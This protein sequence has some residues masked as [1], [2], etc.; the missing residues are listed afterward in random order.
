MTNPDDLIKRSDALQAIAQLMLEKVPLAGDYITT[1]NSIPAASSD[2]GEAVAVVEPIG[3]GN[4]EAML[5]KK[6]PVGTMLY[7]AAPQQAIPAGDALDVAMDVLEAHGLVEVYERNLS[8]TPT[9]P[10]D[11]VK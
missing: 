10:I 5:L 7:L 4:V 1:L 8:A 9:A 6:L 3:D 2:K 11:G